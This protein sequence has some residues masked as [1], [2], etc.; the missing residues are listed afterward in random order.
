MNSE[1][2]TVPFEEPQRDPIVDQTAVRMADEGIPVRA[3]AR[4]VRLPS[5]EVYEILKDAVQRGT[6][7]ELPKNDWPLGSTRGQRAAFN[8]TALESDEALQ[9]ACA[10]CFRCTRLEAAILGVLLKRNEVMKAQLHLV[11]EQMRPGENRPPTDPKMVDVIICHLRKK[12]KTHE[13]TIKTVWGRGYRIPLL[14]REKAI[15]I[16]THWAE[17]EV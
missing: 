4:S 11:I 7:V 8:G 1:A 17:A 3:I 9:M 13:I 12:L 10:R 2:E 14:D 6:I 15:H 5:E 16:L